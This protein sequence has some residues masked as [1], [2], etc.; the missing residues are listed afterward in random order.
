MDSQL[1]WFRKINVFATLLFFNVT[2]PDIAIILASQPRRV[3]KAGKLRIYATPVK[4]PF[5]MFILA[6]N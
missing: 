2:F 5:E 3:A 4:S 1:S 6:A